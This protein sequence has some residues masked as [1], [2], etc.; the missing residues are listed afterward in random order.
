MFKVSY[1]RGMITFKQFLEQEDLSGTNQPVEPMEVQ[2]G[3][4]VAVKKWKATKAE[5]LSYWQNLPPDTPIYMKPIDYEHQGS[6]YGEDGLRITGRPEFIA[7]VMSRLKEFLNF[8]NPTTKLAVTYR[9][10]ESP[11]QVKMGEIKT[12]YVFYV[13]A[14][15]RGSAKSKV[16]NVNPPTA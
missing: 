12:S 13:S 8:E 16:L 3:P 2:P 15:E 4:V 10:T 14:R 6:T 1:I 5:I 7:S 9:Q 11:S